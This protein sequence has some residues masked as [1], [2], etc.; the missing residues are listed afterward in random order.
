LTR[1]RVRL[2]VGVVLTLAIVGPLGWLWWSSLLPSSYSVM[3]MG[4]ADYG[5]GPHAPTHDMASME[6]MEHAAGDVSVTSLDT[7]K[8]GRPD[9]VVDLT[10]RQGT[11]KLASGDKVEGYSINGTSPGPTI[12]ATV[13]DLVEVHV[14]NENVSGGIAIHWHGV[15]VPNA[16]DGVAGVTQNAIKSGKDHTYRWV[17]PHA[18]TYWYH[19]HQ[20]SNE[21][22]SGGLLGG[23]EIRPKAPEPGV[24]DVLALSHLYNGTQTLNGDTGDQRVTAKPGQ[25]V[26]V[27]LVN[28]DNGA[29][30]AWASVPYR[31]VAVD[32]QD[33]NEPGEVSDKEVEIPAGGRNDLEV[34]VPADGSAARVLLAG[35][36]GLVIGPDGAEAP[37]VD[38]PASRLD[39]LHYGAPAPT[40]IDTSHPDRKFDYS[41]DR[42]PGFID[43]KPGLW[44][45][46]NG[47]LYPDMPMMT[48][49]E[50]D[51]VEVTISNHSGKAHPMHLHG[52]HAIVLSRDGTKT[53]GSPWW[54]DSLEVRD[55]E[56]FT[57]AFVADNPGIWMDHCHNL[58]HAKQGMITHLMYE[59]VSTPYKLG[60]DS[61]NE[62]E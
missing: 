31:L 41:I 2:L 45:S 1:A 28:T 35:D 10:A 42:K 18:G 24:Q 26:R 44:W 46:I 32:G 27:R 57:V 43:G 52:H 34:T 50:G 37:K 23:I 12:E 11:V 21:Q 13:G 22:V 16:E 38:Q 9:V 54:F 3:N 48:V 15:D 40:G 6:G 33:V 7:P 14:R 29:L 17:A 19:S 39:L 47:H 36:V 25:R 55:G 4:Y 62:P 61:G 56:T 8:G 30:L 49:R 60:S 59:G 58:K 5:G 53:T 20:L 51:V